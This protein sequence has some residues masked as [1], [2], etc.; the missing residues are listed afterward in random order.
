M[1][2]KE[3][4][5]HDPAASAIVMGMPSHAELRTLHDEYHDKPATTGQIASN[6]WAPLLKSPRDIFFDPL[7]ISLRL[8]DWLLKRLFKLTLTADKVKASSKS[9]GWAL[10]DAGTS[11]F[12][13]IVADAFKKITP[14]FRVY[15]AKDGG[16]DV[17]SMMGPHKRRLW[18]ALAE[19]GLRD[20]IIDS[21]KAAGLHGSLSTFVSFEYSIS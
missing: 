5:V 17:C 11:I 15:E 7:H 10:F 21:L 14:A 19:P 13:N 16:L 20:T 18:N 8:C 12:T 4:A 1:H 3:W 2:K 6:F 9:K